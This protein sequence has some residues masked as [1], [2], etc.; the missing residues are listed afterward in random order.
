M[1]E[2]TIGLRIQRKGEI[3]VTA[4]RDDSWFKGTETRESIGNPGTE[5]ILH[6]QSQKY[7]WSI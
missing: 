5:K 2:E 3:K 6:A 4:E 7:K 1:K